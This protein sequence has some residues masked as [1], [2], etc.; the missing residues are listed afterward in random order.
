MPRPANALVVDDEPH[1]LVLLRT[2]LR[3]LGIS[4][5][6]EAAD[7]IEALRQAE[8]HKPD[9][10]L[11]DLNLPQIDGLHV[12]EKLKADYP[13]IP[14]IVVSAQSTQKTFI[15]ARELGAAGYILK[16]APNPEL[17]R[18]LSEAFDRLGKDSG[19]AAPAKVPDPTG[20]PPEKP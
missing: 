16:Y 18:M 5:V 15:R 3:K 11:L 13:G 10:V 1:V 14:V 4:P 20:T 2:L 7:G 6:W 8:A 12:L 9:V 19:A 17:L